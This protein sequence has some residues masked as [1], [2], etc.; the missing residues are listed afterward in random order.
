[1]LLN[2][3]RAE[4][5]IKIFVNEKLSFA[6]HYRQ[7]DLAESAREPRPSRGRHSLRL[8]TLTRL[9]AYLAH[10]GI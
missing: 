1:M 5:D 2:P 8:G 10:L 7:I 3:Y 6:E 9:A 4:W